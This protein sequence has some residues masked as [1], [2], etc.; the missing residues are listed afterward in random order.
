MDEDVLRSAAGLM[1]DFG[2]KDAA[3][4]IR[5]HLKGGTADRNLK[6]PGYNPAGEARA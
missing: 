3:T 1:D 2:I 4:A 6:I 5:R